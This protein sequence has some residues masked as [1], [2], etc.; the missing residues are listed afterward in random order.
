MTELSDDRLAA[1]LRST[2]A[3]HEHLADPERALA[4]AASSAPPPRR[5]RLL[6]AAAAAV[7]LVA[8]TSYAVTRGSDAGAPSSAPR[9]PSP[10]S[11]GQ[12]P[13]PPLQTDA[14]NRAA[15]A[16]A[17]DRTI[18]RVPT[19][20]GARPSAAIPALGEVYSASGPA[21][22]TV[23]RTRWW[24]VPGSSPQAV[25]QWYGDHP[26][27]GFVS[28]GFASAGGSDAPAVQ[29]VDFDQAPG[30][31]LPPSGLHVVVETTTTTSGVGVRETVQ[32]LWPPARPLASYVQDVRSIEVHARH[33]HYGRHASSSQRSFVVTDPQRVLRA[34][35]AFDAL[36]GQAPFVHSCPPMTDVWT[37]RFVF[38]TATGDV[39]A[40]STSS[41]CGIGMQVVRDGRRVPPYLAEPT[42]L[43]RVLGLRH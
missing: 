15:A 37:D 4:L 2:F 39:T 40:V 33:D 16:R 5:G 30:D 26:A 14:G 1:V 25:A 10:T 8:G 36:P 3:A 9:T 11:S 17:A 13:L 28:S 35:A 19:Y 12:P 7:A 21:A 20:P 18:A 24:T 38:H 31:R 27:P 41:S 6:L 43:L 34:A 22:Y 23:T 42:A 32:S 29:I